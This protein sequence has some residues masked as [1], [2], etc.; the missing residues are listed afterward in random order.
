MRYLRIISVALLLIAT[1]TFG[2]CRYYYNIAIDSKP[3]VISME[4]ESIKVSVEDPEEALLAGITVTDNRDGDVTDSLFVEKMDNFTTFGT[5][6]Y[7][8]VACDKAGNISK[9]TRE[10]VYTD[11]RK[12][13]FSLSEPLRFPLGT[14]G[15]VTNIGAK[16]V[17]EGDINSQVRVTGAHSMS[18]IAGDYPMEFA[19]TNEA[20]D[21]STITA[22]VTLYDIAAENVKPKIEL[23]DYLVYA[24]R[25]E[26]VRVTD[27]VKSM[28]LGNV[29]YIHRGSALVPKNERFVSNT[30]PEE[31]ALS[32]LHIS[33]GVDYSNPGTYEIVYEYTFEGETG[34]VRLIVVVE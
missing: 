31:I 16:D 7:A 33:D 29:E 1:L 3:P 4:S 30:M 11:Y 21:T 17:I 28:K 27:Y 9:A 14:T 26:K 19:V 20:G 10:L 23:K 18:N 22:T 15:I 8:V 12:P 24:S 5:R 6:Q 13:Q 34:T 25:T 32:K 2:V